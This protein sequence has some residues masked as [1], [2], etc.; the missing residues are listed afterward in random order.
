MKVA[1]SSEA[2]GMLDEIERFIARDNPQR[3]ESFIERL[4]EKGDSIASFPE[5]GRIVPEFS[6]SDLREILVGNYRIVYRATQT[7]IIILT[8]FEGHRTLHSEEL[9]LD[10]ESPRSTLHH[11]LFHFLPQ[12]RISSRCGGFGV[13][14]VEGGAGEAHLFNVRAV[15]NRLLQHRRIIAEGFD[16]F[17][18]H[19][20]LLLLH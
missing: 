14:C 18:V 3:A 6:R 16:Y 4:L 9:D 2:L 5:K 10:N 1:W 15:G 13:C 8:V 12:F 20:F 11:P 19:R 17:A 7:R